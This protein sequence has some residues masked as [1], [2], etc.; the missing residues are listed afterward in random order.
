MPSRHEGRWMDSSD[1]ENVKAG[2]R[3]CAWTTEGTYEQI[4]PQWIDHIHDPLYDIEARATMVSATVP[5]EDVWY[6]LDLLG[7]RADGIA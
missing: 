3:T 4:K 2:C 1:K 7:E 6:L 5:I